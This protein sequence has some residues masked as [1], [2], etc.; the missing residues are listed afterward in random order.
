M[1]KKSFWIVRDKAGR[2]IQRVYYD[3][4]T[5]DR[6]ARSLGGS[7]EQVHPKL[8]RLSCTRCGKLLVG[9]EEHAARRCKQ[10]IGKKAIKGGRDAMEMR[11][12]GSFETGKGR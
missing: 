3:K 4:A 11:L 7:V 1:P 10:C 9:E 5:A 12:P 2:P 8:K 6:R